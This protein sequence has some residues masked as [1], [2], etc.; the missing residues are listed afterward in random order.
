MNYLKTYK[1]GKDSKNIKNDIFKAL[2]T[3]LSGCIGFLLKKLIYLYNIA[4]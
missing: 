4:F 1:I 3:E 2:K